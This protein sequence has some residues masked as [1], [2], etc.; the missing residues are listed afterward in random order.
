MLI[1]N[2]SVK[3]F[4]NFD[5][6]HL[7]LDR[8]L[9]I[10]Y[11]NNGQ[12]KTN[13]L[14][15]IYLCATGRSQRAGL[16]REMIRF[17]QKEAHVRATILEGSDRIDIHLKRDEKKGVAINGLPV[18]KLGELFGTLLVVMFSPEDLSLVKAGPAV[19]RHFMDMELCQ[20]SPV[21]YHHI[22]QYYRIL[23]QRNDLLKTLRHKR[24]LIDT[25]ELWDEQLAESGGRIIA[26]RN[27]FVEKLNKSAS[28]LHTRI[29]NHKESLD[30]QYRPHTSAVYLK[31]K[32]K[33]TLERDIM[34]GST[35]SGI[36]K[37]ELLFF[38]NGNDARIYGSQGQQR[39]ASLAA[40]L[41][42][43]D[44]IRGEKG[45]KP[46][47]LLDDVLSE[48]DKT[49]QEWLMDAIQSIQTVVTCTG[50]EDTIKKISA[51][52]VIYHVREGKIERET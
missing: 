47:L 30:I 4:R 39:C 7:T 44:L 36:H 24:E 2:M 35:S 33:K 19:R 15:S 6:Q 16:D 50:V 3:D 37:D 9:N 11:G 17:G 42:E 10:L 52:A 43:I 40:K 28:E 1:H 12:G 41:A 22:Q 8:G 51:G 45:D 13:F 5:E 26:Y 31:D 23:R 29:T 38:I 27:D 48:L 14:E 21:Y 46:V 20:I 18:K 25:V 32:L 49:R 34:L